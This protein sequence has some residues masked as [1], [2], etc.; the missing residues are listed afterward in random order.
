MT[1]ILYKALLW[2]HPAAFRRRFAPEMLCIF[3]E[4]ALKGGTAGLAGDAVVSLL[5]QWMLRSGAWIAIAALLGAVIQV[6]V[7]GFSFFL[8]G[9]ATGMASPPGPGAPLAPESAELIQLMLWTS[10]SL[11]VIVLLTTLWIRNFTRRIGGL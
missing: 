10:G 3:D 8:F 1:R 6:T 5:R 11:I 2:L 9:R 7:G 4:V